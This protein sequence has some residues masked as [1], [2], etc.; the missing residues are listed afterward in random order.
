LNDEDYTLD[1]GNLVIAD[2]SGAIALAGVIARV[3]RHQ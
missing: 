1:P 3:Y 2:A